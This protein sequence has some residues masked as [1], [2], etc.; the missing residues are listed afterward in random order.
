MKTVNYEGGSTDG[1][2][3]SGQKENIKPYS[4]LPPLP[5]KKS[6]NPKM[7][8][9]PLVRNNKNKIKIPKKT[10]ELKLNI[11]DVD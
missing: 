5:S 2:E 8:L 3:D 11:M 6:V 10:P 1:E 4:S 9:P 7:S